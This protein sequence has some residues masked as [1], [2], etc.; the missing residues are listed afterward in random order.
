MGILLTGDL[1]KKVKTFWDLI[2]EEELV[3]EVND[4]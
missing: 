3:K 2:L 1:A 4:F